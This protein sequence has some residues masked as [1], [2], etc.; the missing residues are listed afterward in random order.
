MNGEF[1]EKLLLHIKGCWIGII[2][3]LI[4]LLVCSV[5]FA[6]WGRNVYSYSNAKVKTK[7]KASLIKKQAKLERL[8]LITTATLFVVIF[9][10][11]LFSH[12]K[13]L[14]DCSNDM[15]YESY[16]TY[17]GAVE[18]KSY[19]SI[20]KGGGTKKYMIFLSDINVEIQCNSKKNDLCE[21]NYDD[22]T[23]VYSER[24]KIL[25]WI[26]NCSD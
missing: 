15:K 23:V 16:V 1:N 9:S 2:F 5:F 17:N 21:G 14:V 8:E 22:M 11:A 10:T 12:I 19:Y 24:S 13:S 3:L 18:V 7:R 25:L 20:A 26:S 4:I 6:I